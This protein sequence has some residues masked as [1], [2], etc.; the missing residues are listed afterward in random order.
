VPDSTWTMQ[1]GEVFEAALQ[2]KH[3]SALHDLIAANDPV[4]AGKVIGKRLPGAVA[5][6]T[7]NEHI[8]HDIP[9][10]PIL[11]YAHAL[12]I[13]MGWPRPALGRKQYD[14]HYGV[15]ER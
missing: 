1:A 14:E 2:A 10:Q 8:G 4:L 9:N 12:A 15:K 11:A 13:K 3:L 5:R 7:I 6:V